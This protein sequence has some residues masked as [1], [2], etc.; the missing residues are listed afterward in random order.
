MT[1]QGPAI[2]HGAHKRPLLLYAARMAAAIIL[3][4]L[5]WIAQAQDFFTLK[6]HGGPIKGV[7]SGDDGAIVTASFDNSVGV[8]RDGS[9]QWLEGHTAAV[10]AV[11]YLADGR[12]VSAGDDFSV[13]VWTPATRTSRILGQHAGKVIQLA[14]SPDGSRVASASWDGTARIWSLGGDPSPLSITGHDNVVND[15]AF[16]PDGTRLYTA[17]ADGTLRIWD[18]VTGVLVRRLVQ[19]GFGINTLE[20][21]LAGRWITYGAVDGATRVIA[22]AEAEIMYDF[23]ADRRPILA[24]AYHEGAARIAVGDA[25]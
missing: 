18:A 16:S 19:H 3:M 23:T 14:L 24:M 11:A 5:S 15:V 17:S 4:T 25:L 7:V 9:A 2:K 20:I 8:W 1:V 6:G 13:R 22:V 12:V 10:N 21:D